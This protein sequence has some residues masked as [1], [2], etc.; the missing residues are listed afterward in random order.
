MNQAQQDRCHEL[1]QGLLPNM[2]DYVADHARKKSGSIALIEH[3]T[4]N[5]VTWKKFDTAVDTFAAK[6]RAIGLTQKEMASYSRPSHVVV[7]KSGEIPLNRVAQNGLHGPQ[8]NGTHHREATSKRRKVGQL[9]SM[10]A[11]TIMSTSSSP[12]SY[13]CC[14]A[15]PRSLSASSRHI[16]VAVSEIWRTPTMLSLYARQTRES[17]RSMHRTTPEKPDFYVIVTPSLLQPARQGKGPG[18]GI[19]DLPGLAAASDCVIFHAAAV[20]STA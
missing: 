7:L 9:K 1:Y 16:T 19:D 14:R 12:C 5:R 20:Q 4:G 3:N 15:T 2:A 17:H 11:F 6:L 10:S 8:G 18:N 13:P